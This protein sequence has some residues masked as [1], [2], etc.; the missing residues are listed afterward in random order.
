M[1]D[2]FATEGP[3]VLSQLTSRQERDVQLEDIAK[4]VELPSLPVPWALS[5]S[6]KELI[7]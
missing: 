7:E 3:T 5:E 6:I 4:L 1:L 2:L